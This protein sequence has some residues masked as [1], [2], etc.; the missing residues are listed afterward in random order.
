VYRVVC[1]N[2]VCIMSAVVH[3]KK[4]H[5]S[6]K[7]GERL[8]AVLGMIACVDGRLLLSHVVGAAS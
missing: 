8:T 5:K 7:S 3:P 6:W 2:V 1:A 4:G